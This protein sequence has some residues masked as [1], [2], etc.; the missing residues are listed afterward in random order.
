MRS[1]HLAEG[2]KKQRTSHHGW[3]ILIQNQSWDRAP[4]NAKP[5]QVSCGLATSWRSANRSLLQTWESRTLAHHYK[6]SIPSWPG[7]V[8]EDLEMRRVT[9]S[10]FVLHSPHQHCESSWCGGLH[11][12][13]TSKSNGGIMTTLMTMKS[14]II[15]NYSSGSNA[16]KPYNGWAIEIE[17]EY[18]WMWPK[19][20]KKI[21]C[22][23]QMEET[24]C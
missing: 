9:L 21:F 18:V 3:P 10:S 23:L 14:K 4:A 1:M 6:G 22:L 11:L 2:P 19:K 13:A 7:V 5:E 24:L 16:L 15:W 12:Q 20:V 8:E 17:K